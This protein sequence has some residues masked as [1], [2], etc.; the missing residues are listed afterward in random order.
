VPTGLTQIVSPDN[1]VLLVGR[2]PAERDSDPPTAYNLAHTYRS[3]R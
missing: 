3:H 2:V 1:S